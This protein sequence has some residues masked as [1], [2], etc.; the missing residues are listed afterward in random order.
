M[1]YVVSKET[2]AVLLTVSNKNFDIGMHSDIL[3]DLVWIIDT[4]ELC[5]LI[6]VYLTLTLIQGDR[7]A[8][9]Q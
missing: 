1:R 2:T 8:T 5:I 6:L 3:I 4:I 9:R 7:D